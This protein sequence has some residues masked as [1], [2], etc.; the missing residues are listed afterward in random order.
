MAEI[1]AAGVTS[2]SN[3]IARVR[4]AVHDTNATRRKWSADEVYLA[5]AD[6]IGLASNQFFITGVYTDLDFATGTVEYTLPDYIH[7]VVR[8]RRER[9]VPN[10]QVDADT[11]LDWEEITSWRHVRSEIG[12]N[13]LF[14]LKPQPDGNTEITYE[15]DVP[16]PFVESEL[17]AA[18][19]TTDG[20]SITIALPATYQVY[21]LELP[22]Y[23]QINGAEIVK[24]TAITSA[25]VATIVR[26]QLG[27]TATTA[28]QGDSVSAIILVNDDRFN[29]YVVNS[30]AAYLNLMILQD[31]NRGA[32]VAGNLTAMREF[33]QRANRA[34]RSKTARQRPRRV[35]SER[36]RRRSNGLS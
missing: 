7:R 16:I 32:D 6:A 19:S 36:G 9:R 10:I 21:G 30:A 2:V 33:D 27:T 13:K 26:A 14:L 24:I 11:T 23:A 5:I 17:S 29:A 18:L 35:L 34:L 4:V 15:R 28:S 31:A 1:L 12:N 25:G 22:M 8:V 3:L 20:T